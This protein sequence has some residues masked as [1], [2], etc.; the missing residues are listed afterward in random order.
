M[1]DMSIIREAERIIRRARRLSKTLY[2]LAYVA[3]SDS[4]YA[5]EALQLLTKFVEN[6]II[7]NDQLN[8]ILQDVER[9]KE[10]RYAEYSNS[11]VEKMIEN[12]KRE[13]RKNGD[14]E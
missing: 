12:I 3:L 2:Q 8:K 9:W 7:T 5:N 10:R 14:E 4:P 6:R 1:S 11:E 13:L